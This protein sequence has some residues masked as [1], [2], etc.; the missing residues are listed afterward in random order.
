MVVSSVAFSGEVDFRVDFRFAVENASNR[1]K[2]IAGVRV[3]NR[4]H[5]EAEPDGEHDK[6]QHEKL[7]AISVSELHTRSRFLG[8][9]LMCINQGRDCYSPLSRRYVPLAA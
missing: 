1:S 4:Q 5:E 7:L 3:A 8:T 6:V 9:I 2:P